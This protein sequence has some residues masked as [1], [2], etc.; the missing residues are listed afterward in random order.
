MA[1]FKTVAR[2]SEIAPGTMTLVDL[3]GE[4]VVIANSEG[5]FFAF[6]NACTHVGGPLVEGELEGDTVTC[7][8]SWRQRT[9]SVDPDRDRPN[10][11]PIVTFRVLGRS[12]WLSSRPLPG[13]RRLPQAR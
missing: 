7:P 5:K 3:D 4:E 11:F 12:T 13:R 6:S 10:L 8:R 1:Q 9:R 2:V